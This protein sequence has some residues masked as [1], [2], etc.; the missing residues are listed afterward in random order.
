[1]L[2]ASHDY[3]SNILDDK[4]EKVKN[5]EKLSLDMNSNEDLEIPYKVLNNF[6]EHPNDRYVIVIENLNEYGKKG[7]VTLVPCKLSI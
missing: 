7:A 5:L 1:M 4:K 6:D 2:L 3:S